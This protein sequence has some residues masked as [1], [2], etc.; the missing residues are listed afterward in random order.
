MRAARFAGEGEAAATVRG[1]STTSPSPVFVCE[2]LRSP[3]E[4]PYAGVVSGPELVE[5]TKWAREQSYVGR[6]DPEAFWGPWVN[7]HDDP[8][9]AA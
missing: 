5:R 8:E 2:P 9:A 4:G 1:E 7:P 3:T 6:G